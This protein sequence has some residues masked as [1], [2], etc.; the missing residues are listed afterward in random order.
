MPCKYPKGTEPI[1]NAEAAIRADQSYCQSRYS[2]DTNQR[3]NIDRA[4]RAIPHAG[5]PHSEKPP[6]CRKVVQLLAL[7]GLA[8]F[9]TAP[10]RRRHRTPSRG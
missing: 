10:V 5:T 3:L 9:Y 1:D 7:H 2:P 8:R 6:L 4:W